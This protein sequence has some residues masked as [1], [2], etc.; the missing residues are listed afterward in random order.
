M[1]TREWSWEIGEEARRI[2][3]ADTR[4]IGIDV[5]YGVFYVLAGFLFVHKPDYSGYLIMP[6]FML[7]VVL[8]Y[9]SMRLCSPEYT[10][11]TA[12]FYANLPRR[13]A[14]TYWMHAAWLGLFATAMEAIILVGFFLQIVFSPDKPHLIDP[15]MVVLPYLVACYMLWAIYKPRQWFIDSP[16][17]II[18]PTLCIVLFIA[19]VVSTDASGFGWRILIAAILIIPTVVLLIN[20][21]NNWKKT[22]TGLIV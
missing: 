17:A 6:F 4:T 18:F 15:V 20:G 10:G 13:R 7:S 21:S 9:L 3:R 22:E 2:V 8:I 5:V 19:D 16:A 14:A 12:M 1:T 11:G